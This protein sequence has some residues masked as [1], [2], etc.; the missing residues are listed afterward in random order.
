MSAWAVFSMMGF[1]PDCPGEPYYTLTTPTFD[2]V[3]IDTPSGTITI[4]AKHGSADDIYIS[5]MQLN[6]KALTKYRISHDELI[7]GKNLKF[8]LSNS[9]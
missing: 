4:D 9:K 3:E 6:G 7:N 8:N 2:R 5:S 1:Y